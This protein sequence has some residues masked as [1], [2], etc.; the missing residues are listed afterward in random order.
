MGL[1][2]T[3]MLPECRDGKLSLF[4]STKFL[5][6]MAK[7]EQS[8]KSMT[9]PRMVQSL[10]KVFMVFFVALLAL[11]MWSLQVLV[12]SKQLPNKRARGSSRA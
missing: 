6:C 11:F 1:K 9:Y 5:Q 10:Q 2:S 12:T 7:A 3:I 8:I 4:L